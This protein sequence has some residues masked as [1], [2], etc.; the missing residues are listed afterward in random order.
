MVEAKRSLPQAST[1]Y[2]VDMILKA[3][4]PL[5]CRQFDCKREAL[6]YAQVLARLPDA[7]LVVA[8]A[9]TSEGRKKIT[10]EWS[11]A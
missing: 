3:I 5:E 6:A 9:V 2:W 10:F 8:Y 7:C 4:P 11:E 1:K